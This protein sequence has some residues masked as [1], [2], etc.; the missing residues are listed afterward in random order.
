MS[1]QEP[2]IGI[3]SW[4]S[5][6]VP[7][8]GSLFIFQLFRC[9][10]LAPTVEAGMGICQPRGIH[11]PSIHLYSPHVLYAP[12][13]SIHPLYICMPHTPCT[14]VCSMFPIW[15]RDLG[16]S[17]H[18]ICLG[19]FL[20]CQYICHAFHCLLVHPFASQFITVMPVAPHHCGL[21]LCWTEC[22]WMSAMFHAVFPFFIV[23][24]MSQASTTIAMATTPC[25]YWYIVSSLNGYHGPPLMEL[26]ATS[27]QH[28]TKAL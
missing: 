23:F 6:P 12:C 15:H 8:G 24:I 27:G 21:L 26:L 25:V 28:D 16:A 3:S 22:L 17:V 13:M 1:C 2:P 11:T 14:S 9:R 19:V 5:F 4:G 20:E 18:P 10:N 7:S